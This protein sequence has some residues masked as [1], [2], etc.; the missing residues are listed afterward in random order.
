[1][2]SS[3]TFVLVTWGA[4]ALVAIVFAYEVYTVLTEQ[5]II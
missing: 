3:T 1:M 5:G 2:I 4:I